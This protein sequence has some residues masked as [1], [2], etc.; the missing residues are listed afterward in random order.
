MTF[1]T[2]TLCVL[3]KAKSTCHYYLDKHKL[4]FS[5]FALHVLFALLQSNCWAAVS[6]ALPLSSVFSP[7]GGTSE[8]LFPGPPST[9]C[10]PHLLPPPHHQEE[11]HHLDPGINLA[12]CRV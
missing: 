3:K 7:H 4:P 8:A 2:Y 9:T 11:F 12:Q 1:I 5:Y 6:A 10:H